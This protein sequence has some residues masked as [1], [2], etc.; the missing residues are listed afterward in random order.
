MATTLSPEQT[1]SNADS[2]KKQRKEQ[3][4]R[5]AKA[6]LKLEQ[7]QQAVHKAEQKLAKTQAQLEARRTHLRDLEADLN[8]MRNPQQQDIASRT[9]ETT[10]RAPANEENPADVSL[11]ANQVIS[12]PPTEGRTDI[13]ENNATPPS[14]QDEEVTAPSQE[15]LGESPVAAVGET[16]EAQQGS[17]ED[18]TAEEHGEETS[19]SRG[20]RRTSR[21]RRH[22]NPGDEEETTEEDDTDAGQ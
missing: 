3:A 17:A 2:G 6:M 12:M 21:S 14:A 8:N 19:T 4:K 7:A 5:E 18:S 16:D 11:P 9:A 15:N 20:T 22:S 1:T 10:V 13:S